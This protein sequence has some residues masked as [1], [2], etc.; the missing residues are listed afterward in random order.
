MKAFF[1]V[2]LPV[3]APSRIGTC[4]K[5]SCRACSAKRFRMVEFFDNSCRADFADDEAMAS[6]QNSFEL[7]F[8]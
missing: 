8:L 3:E 7:F 6:L 4:P 5:I 1:A 2:L